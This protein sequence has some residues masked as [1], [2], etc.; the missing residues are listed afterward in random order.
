M[1]EEAEEGRRGLGV[2]PAQNVLAVE[3]GGGGDGFGESDGGGG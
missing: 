3:G 2:V 1:R